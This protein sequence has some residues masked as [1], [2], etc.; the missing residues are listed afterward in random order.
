MGLAASQS[1]LQGG[2]GTGA[3]LWQRL[4]VQE[5]ILLAKTALIQTARK[6]LEPR[7]SDVPARD[8][9]PV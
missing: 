1:H 3:L 4:V 2:F 7:V 6:Q 5:R 9:M 8:R